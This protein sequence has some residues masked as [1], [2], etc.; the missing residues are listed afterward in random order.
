[1]ANII[2]KEAIREEIAQRVVEQAHPGYNADYMGEWYVVNGAAVVH[3]QRNAQWNPW[4]D[5]DAV[6]AVDDLVNIY[7]GADAE[8]AVF[9]PTPAEGY[10]AETGTEIA[11]SFALGYVPAEY[12]AAA[13][14]ARWGE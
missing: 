12:D 13:Y 7:G 11:V 2:I 4:Q 8:H 1:M 6:I 10:D 5:D 3:C 9:D 14:A